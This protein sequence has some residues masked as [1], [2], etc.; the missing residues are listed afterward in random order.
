L[1]H[2]TTDERGKEAVA[3]RDGN[4]DGGDQE[5][6]AFAAPLRIFAATTGVALSSFAR[7]RRAGISIKR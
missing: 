1:V 7:D 6:Q 2:P 4:A 3:E 5:H